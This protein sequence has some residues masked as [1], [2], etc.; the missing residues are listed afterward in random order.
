M[1]RK[2]LRRDPLSE[3]TEYLK[4][5]KVTFDKETILKKQLGINLALVGLADDSAQ[6]LQRISQALRFAED[7]IFTKEYI[8]NLSPEDVVALWKLAQSSGDKERSFLAEVRK[9][10]DWNDLGTQ[11]DLSLVD[12]KNPAD[13]EDEDGEQPREVRENTATLLSIMSKI[14][15]NAK[16]TGTDD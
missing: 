7:K 11:L 9:Y 4:T 3:S 14:S 16:K 5:G 12:G 8:Q 1:K 13:E 15:A 6:R 2:K 10:L